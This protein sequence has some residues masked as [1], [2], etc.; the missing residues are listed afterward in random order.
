MSRHHALAD[1]LLSSLRPHGIT[2]TCLNPGFFADL[3]YMQL[4][5]YAALLGVFPWVGDTSSKNAPP[6]CHDIARVGVACLQDP[7][8]H[9]GKTYRPTGPQAR[10]DAPSHPSTRPRSTPRRR[11]AP[12]R[13]NSQLLSVKEMVAIMERVLGR[14]ISIVPSSL[15]LLN[16]AALSENQGEYTVSQLGYYLHDHDMNAFAHNAPST[17]VLDVTGTPVLAARSR[18]AAAS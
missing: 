12:P 8:A 5:T 3:P 4:L 13:S 14:K 10:A 6:S 18:A 1:D 11:E 15:W 16:K 9:A 2:Y 7:A 17:D